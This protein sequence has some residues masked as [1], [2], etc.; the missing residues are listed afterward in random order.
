M[1]HAVRC[2]RSSFKS[3]EFTVGLNVVLA[4]KG[5]AS[6]KG[7]TRNGVGKSTLIEVIH[8]C[9]GGNP[10][11]TL[12]KAQVQGWTFTLDLT[13][14]GR[15]V[16]VSRT[17]GEAGE[18]RLEGDTEGWPADFKTGESG[19]KVL[20][21]GAWNNLLG[22]LMFGLPGESSGKSDYQPTFRSL[23]SYFAR[24]TQDAYSLPFEHYRKQL[25][26]D[27]QVNNAYLLG[28]NWE[29]A[30]RWQLL[31]DRGEQL[32]NLKKAA[33]GGLLAEIIGSVKELRNERA[34]LEREVERRRAD[35]EAF[36]VRDDYRHMER[37][38]D[39]ITRDIRLLNDQNF[40]DLQLVGSYE[41]SSEAE[42]DID[43]AEVEELYLSAQVALGEAVVRHL[44]E[45]REFHRKLV[46]NRR[47]F[48]MGEA[49]RLRR[50]IE[51]RGDRIARLQRGRAEVM[52]V[53]ESSRA[54]EEYTRLREQLAETSARLADVN[55]RIDR[56]QGIQ[57]EESRLKVERGELEEATQ[58][59][60]DESR[61]RWSSAMALFNGFSQA[62]YSTPGRLLIDAG[63]NG[64]KFDV[65]IER[66]DAEGIESMKVF[67]YDLTLA[68]LWAQ[69]G[70]GP[71]FVIH[72]S[73][74]FDPVDSRQRAEAIELAARS[75]SE[76]GFQYVCLLNS[77]MVPREEFDPQ[78][79]FDSHV[80]LT[81]TDEPDGSL[82]GER[83]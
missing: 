61:E 57:I 79:D 74:L 33:A 17:A 3:V 34:L 6:T 24:R 45:A 59:D 50:A 64:F 53:L 66:A 10:G 40:A 42:R 56:L 36:Q 20:R 38:A 9:L 75:S 12:A 69:A 5:E 4:V 14:A 32:R 8:F 77:D 15:R 81:L 51:E 43:P 11:K 46:A 58:R 83:F 65:E 44:G 72:D 27:R 13:L 18:V 55:L 31:R 7:D 21:V 82:L 63:A 47:S 76:A 67:C 16:G 71:G 49:Q 25:E 22:T 73:T 1:I 35:L 37:Q 28:L 23:V 26:W 39:E 19:E 68:T 78:F 70:A 60:F 80:R 62:L 2:D 41:R 48:L 54:L 52:R 29:H 30:R